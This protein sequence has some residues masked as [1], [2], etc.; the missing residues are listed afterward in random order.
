MSAAGIA[1]LTGI[2]TDGYVPMESDGDMDMGFEAVIN[3]DE[4]LMI[5]HAG[6]ELEAL[7]G[8]GEDQ[9]LVGGFYRL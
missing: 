4:P 5:S 1:K 6:G 9:D 7:A 2:V 3:G 8:D